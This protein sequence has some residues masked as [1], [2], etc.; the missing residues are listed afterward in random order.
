MITILVIRERPAVTPSTLHHTS[1]IGVIII[2]V[3]AVVIIV[4]I[5]KS[6]NEDE[7][8][9]NIVHLLGSALTLASW[10]SGSKLLSSAL[11]L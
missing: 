7:C 4:I 1:V 11:N 6:N 8:L 9:V 10:P 3:V 5:F 2:V